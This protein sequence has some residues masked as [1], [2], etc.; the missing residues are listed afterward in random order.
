MSTLRII[1][2]STNRTLQKRL[3]EH[4]FDNN[5]VVKEHLSKR[6]GF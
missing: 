6:E 2:H 5:T 3:L 1:I 4:E